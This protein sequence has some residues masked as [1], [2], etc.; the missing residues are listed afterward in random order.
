M[1]CGSGDPEGGG[2]EKNF[3]IIPSCGGIWNCMDTRGPDE[4]RMFEQSN[5]KG[6]P[7]ADRK[8]T[9][10]PPSWPVWVPEGSIGTGLRPVPFYPE[11]AE[12]QK[13]SVPAEI[14]YRPKPQNAPGNR[15]NVD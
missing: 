13:P 10:Y 5:K 11:K 8:E 14:A 15:E 12:S 6:E 3:N 4:Y 9:D 7:A 2:V 1:E